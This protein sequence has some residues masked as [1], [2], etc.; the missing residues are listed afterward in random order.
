M[1]PTRLLLL[2][3]V[4]AALSPSCL[5][6]KKGGKRE[7]P[8][9]AHHVK[10]TG[11]RQHYYVNLKYGEDYMFETADFYPDKSRCKVDY[12]VGDCS[13]VVIET[14][15][16]NLK[17]KQT[18]Y[19]R[20]IGN[21][22]SENQKDQKV[23]KCDEIEY[24][25][26]LHPNGTLDGEDPGTGMTPVYDSILGRF[27][28]PDD[29]GLNED[30]S[31]VFRAG[32]G[33]KNKG[34]SISLKVKCAKGFSHVNKNGYKD[35]QCGLKNESSVAPPPWQL[36]L[37]KD[38]SSEVFSNVF[39]VADTYGLVVLP[40]E[41]PMHEELENFP[42]DFKIGKYLWTIAYIGAP[43]NRGYTPVCLP[44]Q[45]SLEKKL[46]KKA[47]K[48]ISVSSPQFDKKTKTFTESI[49]FNVEV[50][51]TEVCAK[52]LKKLDL[53]PLEEDEGCVVPIKKNSPSV[54]QGSFGAAMYTK[55]HEEKDKKNVALF[56]FITKLPEG[57][58][59]AT[60][61]V[62]ARFQRIGKS[63]FEKLESN[64][65]DQGWEFITCPATP[66]MPN[67]FLE[68][69]GLPATYCNGQETCCTGECV[70]LSESQSCCG[71]KVTVC[72]DTTD[73]NTSFWDC[74]DK[75]A[76]TCGCPS[77]QDCPGIKPNG[78]CAQGAVCCENKCNVN[79]SGGSWTCCG[80]KWVECI[81]PKECI[82]GKCDCPPAQECASGQQCCSPTQ[83]CVN[84][85]CT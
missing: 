26:K 18:C 13:Q 8:E 45:G 16:L 37:S 42:T 54:C 46:G 85:V 65:I 53:P 73:P 1:I 14:L 33:I 66:M 76:G 25:Q 19:S 71:D 41:S 12:K 56:G 32:K 81:S 30:F 70:S 64:V 55:V 40:E 38:L 28:W 22:R 63:F 23:L 52:K 58:E 75:D 67:C 57:I 24:E 17:T 7:P 39:I 31:M 72:E 44:S 21:G 36:D 68:S 4:F 20:I 60:K 11:G 2:L 69:S 48:Q 43:F 78:C 79:P 10:C 3:V 59:C 61:R 6:R 35:C 15:E 49:D 9:E 82:D 80:N 84:D 62:P 34:A 27:E 47:K 77:S 51:P 50:L 74:I 5:G 29:V 83:Q